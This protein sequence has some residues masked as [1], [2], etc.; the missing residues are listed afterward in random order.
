MLA[1]APRP[2]GTARAPVLGMTTPPGARTPPADPPPPDP[3]EPKGCALV[4]AG[5]VIA[6]GS[7]FLFPFAW[8]LTVL[9]L[10]AGGALVAIGVVGSAQ[11]R[12]QRAEP[13]SEAPGS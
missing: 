8:P 13:R 6:V 3:R 4:I 2:A 10:I 11:A 1:R 7:L 12:E 9:G 5:S